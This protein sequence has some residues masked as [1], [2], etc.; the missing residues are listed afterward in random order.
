MKVEGSGHYLRAV[1][2][3]A[4]TVLDLKNT[5]KSQFLVDANYGW[6]LPKL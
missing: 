2:D 1:N 3:G 5:I 4:G 6:P